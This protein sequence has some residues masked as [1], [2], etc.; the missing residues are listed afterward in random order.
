MSEGKTIQQRYLEHMAGKSK[1]WPCRSNRASSLGD[2]CIRKLV[3]Q[4]TCWKEARLPEPEL[5]SI[6]EL[7]NLFE[8]YM[9]RTLEDAG[10]KIFE[11]QRSLEFAEEQITGHLD[12]MIGHPEW[13][14][15]LHVCDIKS[16]SPNVFARISSADDLYNPKYPYMARYPAQITL[17]LLMKA[18]TEQQRGLLL[19]VNKTTGLPKEIWVDLDMGYAETL[20]QKA[21]EINCHVANDTLPQRVAYTPPMCG[22]CEF[23][24]L[25]VPDI[26]DAEGLVWLNDG[27]I[28][29]EIERRCEVE[30]AAHE[31]EAINRM[32]REALKARYE[33]GETRLV[34]GDWLIEGKQDSKG[35]WRTTY[36]RLVPPTKEEQE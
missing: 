35:S 8:G 25:C 10:Y 18:D 3:Y 26:T 14:D 17:Y 21:R 5:Q 9:L 15:T 20:L 19:F 32:L 6:F 29:K 33:R 16:C 30:D 23:R 24:H 1:V 28:V 13:G 22:R 7:G 31:F 34:I 4:R 11:Q 12:C 2:P 27:E 36:E